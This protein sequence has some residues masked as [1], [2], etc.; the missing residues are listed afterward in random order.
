MVT[1][2][3]A[4]ARKLARVPDGL[5]P[6]MPAP[7]RLDIDHPVT[8]DRDLMPILAMPLDEFVRKG[9][10]LEVRVPWLGV[11]L[12]FVPEKRDADMLGREGVNRGR[13]WT[14]EE[15]VGALTL[16]DQSEAVRTIALVKVAFDRL[17]EA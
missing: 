9:K 15:L 7:S 14:T 2:L 1:P 10:L 8:L 6:A 5:A 16:A 12:W 13:V 4:L 17:E 3:E 11:T